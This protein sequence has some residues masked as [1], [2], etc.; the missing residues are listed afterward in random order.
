MQEKL[1]VMWAAMERQAGADRSAGVPQDDAPAAIAA[2][3]VAGGNTIADAAART[4]RPPRRVLV[5]TAEADAQPSPETAAA[6]STPPDI[7]Q[8]P[9]AVSIAK[10]DR[11]RS[12]PA[13]RTS[14]PSPTSASKGGGVLT[15]GAG[16]M[17]LIAAGPA[18]VT[19]VGAAALLRQKVRL[20]GLTS[21]DCR[22]CCSQVAQLYAKP[23]PVKAPQP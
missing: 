2:V 18:L 6:G 19:G 22:R 12:S 14:P 4:E 16:G 3:E 13:A 5:R 17:W 1:D 7:P 23:H 15:G 8:P 9:G 10:L 11:R 21:I 20:V